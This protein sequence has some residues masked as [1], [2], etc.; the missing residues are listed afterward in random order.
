M[1]NEAR[2]K[3]LEDDLNLVYDNLDERISKL[4]AE[5]SDDIAFLGI[6]VSLA[7]GVIQILI[8]LLK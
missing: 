7:I 3:Q 6:A 1:D 2:I 8:A 4:E 5:H